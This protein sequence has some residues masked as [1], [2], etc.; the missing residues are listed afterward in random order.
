MGTNGCK[1]AEFQ[2]CFMVFKQKQKRGLCSNFES[3]QGLLKN[4]SGILKVGEF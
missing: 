1:Q 4:G 3:K 2:N